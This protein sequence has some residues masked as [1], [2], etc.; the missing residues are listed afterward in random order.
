MRGLLFYTVSESVRFPY[1]KGF[2]DGF[3]NAGGRQGDLSVDLP[4][5]SKGR[6]SSI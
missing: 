5:V 6:F 3:L 2:H 1:E 4:H